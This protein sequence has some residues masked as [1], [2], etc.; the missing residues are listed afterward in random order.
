M[1]AVGS[2]GWQ[3]FSSAWVVGRPR[4]G[5]CSK[6]CRYVGTRVGRDQQLL[7]ARLDMTGEWDAA[8]T[9]QLWE[10]QPLPRKHRAGLISGLPW[11]FTTLST[12]SAS[13]V[14]LIG[15][16]SRCDSTSK[17]SGNCIMVHLLA[18]RVRPF[19]PAHV[20]VRPMLAV[21][22]CSA[23]LVSPWVKS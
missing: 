4:R 5:S 1:Y 21:I 10:K 20:M 13:C 6:L 7:Q 3:L 14:A 9:K 2:G 8:G 18:V 11:P 12:R 17:A 23:P 22:G 16:A 19:F 15:L